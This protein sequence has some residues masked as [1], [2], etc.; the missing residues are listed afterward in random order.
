[1]QRFETVCEIPPNHSPSGL[2]KKDADA[3]DTIRKAER[4]LS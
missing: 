2:L 4:F 1:M 3:L